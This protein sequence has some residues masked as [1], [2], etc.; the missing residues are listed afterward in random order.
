[1]ATEPFT[2]FAVAAPG[3]E[4][5]VARELKA[6]GEHPRTEDGGV[7][8]E[9]DTRSVMRA[10]LW[11]RSASRVVV[12]VAR[13]RATAFYDLEK[14]AKRIP[15]ASFVASGR[16]VA[17]RVTAHKSKLYHSEAIA[18]RLRAAANAPPPSEEDDAQ[19]FVV[20][21]VRDEFTISADTSGELLHVRGYRQAVAKAPLRETLAAALL[22]ACD[23]SGESPLLDP[24]CGSG[25]IPIEAAMI[26]RRIAP[27]LH[28]PFAFM[29][30]PEHDESAW[31]ELVTQAESRIVAASPVSILGSDRDAGAIDS[32]R[33]N[34]ERAGV[35]NDIDFG[36]RSISA[37]DP[38][39]GPGLLAT[40]PPYGVRVGR[41]ATLRNLYAQLGNV[42]RKKMP[43]WR[44]V[45][46][47]PGARLTREIGLSLKELLRTTNGGIGVSALV[48]TVPGSAIG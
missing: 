38:P 27:G 28:R 4:Q 21:V 18:E 24:M 43:G 8:W 16:S 42:M 40:N 39:V 3:L 47:S 26:A 30:W 31:R 6:L 19:L 33:A 29:R 46:Y 13:F 37:I 20:R 1:L 14:R 25:T 22:L 5:I 7:S 35:A 32:A 15:W 11:L 36:V 10:N 2:C 48:G 44:L 17:F 9:G 45:L 23:W 41:E 34:A 12:R